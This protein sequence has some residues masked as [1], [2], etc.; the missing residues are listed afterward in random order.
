MINVDFNLIIYTIR[1]I[2]RMNRIFQTTENGSAFRRIEIHTARLMELSGICITVA[3]YPCQK[4]G[5]TAY[6]N[7]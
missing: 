6:G 7:D 1:H 2:P 3:L 5:D 4:L